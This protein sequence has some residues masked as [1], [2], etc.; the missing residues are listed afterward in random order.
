MKSWR[1]E[2]K[3]RHNFTMCSHCTVNSTQLCVARMQVLFWDG[4]MDR[5]TVYGA[6]GRW[7]D[8]PAGKWFV[9]WFVIYRFGEEF[10][11]AHFEKFIEMLKYFR[12]GDE[13]K[14]KA[15]YNYRKSVQIKLEAIHTIFLK[16]GLLLNHWNFLKNQL[17]RKQTL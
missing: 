1:N 15:I 11:S 17:I 2:E 13:T 5:A 3:R 9:P 8:T 10:V 4:R 7:F 6:K 12:E 14:R 16:Y